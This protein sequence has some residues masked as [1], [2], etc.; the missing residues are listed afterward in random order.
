MELMK[1][2]EEVEKYI[3][4]PSIGLPE[5]VFYFVSR[6]TPLVNVD[7]LIKN[8]H[9]ETLLTWREDAFYKGWHIPGGIVRYKE[10]FSERIKQVAKNE[11]GVEVDFDLEP[12]AIHN[13][14]QI[15]R[16]NRGHFIAL[17]FNCRLMTRLD[18]RNRCKDIY[19][20]KINE[21]MWFKSCPKNLLTEQKIYEK[22]INGKAK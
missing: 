22:Y 16:R 13:Q 11:L 8:Q 6:I 18:N 14:I 10:E 5:E 2:I 15:H 4:N 17:L 7:L 19:K 1:L 12:I 3:T 20:P 21:W 9:G